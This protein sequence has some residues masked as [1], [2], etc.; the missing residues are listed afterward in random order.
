VAPSRKSLTCFGNLT[1]NYREKAFQTSE[2]TVNVD[3]LSTIQKLTLS[4]FVLAGGAV[5]FASVVVFTRWVDFAIRRNLVDA[6]GGRKV[7]QTPTPLVGP[8]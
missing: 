8:P 5:S 4:F 2:L 7:H 1:S 3:G 6:G